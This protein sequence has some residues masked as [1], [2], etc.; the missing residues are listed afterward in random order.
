MLPK[1]SKLSLIR[2]KSGVY[3]SLISFPEVSV[4]LHVRVCVCVCVAWPLI[5]KQVSFLEPAASHSSSGLA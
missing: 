5:C 4:S 2:C 1:L 3:K